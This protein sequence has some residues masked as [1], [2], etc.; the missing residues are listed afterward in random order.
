M[1][2][3]GSDNDNVV[4]TAARQAERLRLDIG[5]RWVDLIAT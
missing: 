5:L 2:Q 3:L 4:T 1:G